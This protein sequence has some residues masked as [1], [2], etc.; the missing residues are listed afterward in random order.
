MLC[1]LQVR[2]TNGKASKRG[3]AVLQWLQEGKD[4]LFRWETGR[5]RLLP[6]HCCSHVMACSCAHEKQHTPRTRIEMCTAPVCTACILVTT[7]HRL[8]RTP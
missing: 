1:C 3:L 4:G 5:A 2:K 6:W 8:T 7:A